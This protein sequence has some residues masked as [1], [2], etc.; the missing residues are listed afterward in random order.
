MNKWVFI[1]VSVILI[2]TTAT[3]GVLYFQESSKLK[4]AQ[5]KLAGLEGNVSTIEGDVSNLEG[6]VSALEG[7]VGN[8]GDDVSVLEGGFSS[9]Q[10]DVS[11]LEGGV[12]GLQGDVSNLEG[13]F[14]GLQTDFSTLDDD[15]SNLEGGVSTLE[16]NVSNL[17]GNVSNLEGNVSNLEGN[18]S[19]LEG[20][21]SSLE[22]GV[23]SLEEDVTALEDYN[24]AIM[25]A[26][27]KV[28]PSVV[29]FDTVGDGWY[30]AGS[31]IIITN[32]GWVLTNRHVLEDVNSVEITLMNGQTYDGASQWKYHPTMDFA[33]IKIVSN[34]TDF[35]VATLGSSADLTIGE[36]VL[37]IGYP[38]PFYLDG[39]ASVTTGIVS[40]FRIFDGLDWIQTD[41]AIN[42]G[43]SGGPLVNL[44]GEV[45]GI[46]TL[47]FRVDYDYVWVDLNLT[48]PIDDIKPFVEEGTS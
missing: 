30:G 16:G 40:A 1:A 7:S 5:S 15:V 20:N 27:A 22:G 3:N 13:G 17:E 12:F 24:N 23:S 8:L 4:D 42:Q 18:I 9:L 26:M 46:N 44:K 34:R 28:Q 47:A 6:G 10:G 48:I 33:F 45:V 29:R 32:D 36:K 38:A 21:V 19:N 31:G 11:N 43:N 25:D 41:T 14:S 35:P 37:A 2:A 39:Q